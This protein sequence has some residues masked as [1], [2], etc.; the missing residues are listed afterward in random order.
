VEVALSRPKK[1]DDYK[2][3]IL[4]SE[5]ELRKTKLKAMN[6]VD[7]NRPPNS[8]TDKVEPEL[9]WPPQRTWFLSVFVR[10]LSSEEVEYPFCK[11]AKENAAEETKDCDSTIPG[12][13][14]VDRVLVDTARGWRS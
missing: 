4:A 5:R 2:D 13:E 1:A 14:L 6:V 7:S 9:I 8:A 10:W 12:N 11:T 3:C